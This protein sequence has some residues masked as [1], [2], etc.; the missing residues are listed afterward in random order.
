MAL[1]VM[2]LVELRLRVLRD[3][4][5]GMSVRNAAARYGTSKSQV[6]E[7]LARQRADG[8]DGLLPR[9]RRPLHSPSRLPADIE[10]E[11]V[12]LRKAR[13]RWGAKKIR[14]VLARTGVPAPSV[15]TV[16]RVLVRRG[17]VEVQTRHRPPPGGWQRFERAHSNEL[18]QIDGT[19][20][21]YADG[22]EFWVIDLIDDH[23]RY[24]LSAAVT[25]TLTGAAAWSVVRDAVAEH[26][27]PAQILSDNG[28]YFTGRLRGSTVVFERQ[29]R[30]AGIELIHSRV[31][32]PQTVGKLERQHRTQNDWLADAR[33]VADAAAATA[34][35]AD[36]RHDYNHNRPH[37]AIAQRT[38]A[39]CYQPGVGVELPAVE[40]EPADHYP[41]GCERRRVRPDGTIS[42]RRQHHGRLR[43]DSRWAGVEVG[44]IRHHGQLRVYYGS[45]L[46]DT[47]IIGDGQP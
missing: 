38:P 45:S 26:G 33:A 41:P 39:E 31:G 13:P 43:L 25:A 18:W 29:V 24:L 2:D 20:H 8:V 16:H 27:L 10:D 19:Q 5:L 40:I 21:R 37:E 17:L 15:A 30:A 47:I 28:S 6:Y 7:W 9:S 44:I 32:H 34:L 42:Y 4:E 12:R 22:T 11:I 35:I 36:Y 3:V 1:K 23:S 46:I 14:A